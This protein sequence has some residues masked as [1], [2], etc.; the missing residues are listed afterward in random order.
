[1]RDGTAAGARQAVTLAGKSDFFAYW[2]LMPASDRL[3]AGF[4]AINNH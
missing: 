3:A 2:T 1:M 4:T